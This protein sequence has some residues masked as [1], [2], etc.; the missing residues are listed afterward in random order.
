[1][2]RKRST[3]MNSVSKKKKNI[4]TNII[5]INIG[6]K[7]DK[8]QPRMNPVQSFQPQ[9]NHYSLPTQGNADFHTQ[10]MLYDLKRRVDNMHRLPVSRLVDGQQYENI[11]EKSNNNFIEANPIK[12]NIYKVD[13]DS[14]YDNDLAFP[15]FTDHFLTFK[16]KSGIFATSDK[17]L[18]DA[19]H[20]VD[21]RSVKDRFYSEDR[22]EIVDEYKKYRKRFYNH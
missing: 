15:S 9:L 20:K 16:N 19:I 4:N 11:N 21:H 14:Q 17:D 2:A 5:K 7:Q 13:Q 18:L 1:M 8:K 22:N 6:N 10:T 12:E 3:L